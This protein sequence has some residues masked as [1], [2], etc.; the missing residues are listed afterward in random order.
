MNLKAETRA[1]QL[2]M[3]AAVCFARR[4][5]HRTTMDEIAREAGVSAGLIYR[6]FSSK[7]DLIAA[8]VESYEREALG[9]IEEAT[10]AAVGLEQSIAALFSPSGI[11]ERTEAVLLVEI[12]AEALRN[13][14]IA[15]LIRQNDGVMAARLTALIQAAQA[16]GEADASLSPAAASELLLALRDGLLLRS[17]LASDGELAN[18][19][20]LAVTLTALYRGF[21]GLSIEK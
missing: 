5:F 13:Q 6:H 20:A 16:T 7:E 15:A 8:L 4:G 2:L 12:M 9:R 10:S 1:E 18:T 11:D 19:D 21:L 17:S 14:R 3:A